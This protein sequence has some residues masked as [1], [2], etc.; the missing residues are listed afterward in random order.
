M[1]RTKSTTAV[2]IYQHPD[3]S[4][5]G[6][7]ERGNMQEER[8]RNKCMTSNEREKALQGGLEAGLQ[9]TNEGLEGR[10]FG[11]REG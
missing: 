5:V 2:F 4:S 6:G 8:N 3:A 11:K 1:L 9:K 10:R 7:K